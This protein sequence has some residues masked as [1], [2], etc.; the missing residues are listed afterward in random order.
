MLGDDFYR[1]LRERVA[2]YTGPNAEYLLLAPDLFMLVGRLMLDPRVD[3]RHKAYLGIAMAYVISPIDL[4]PESRFGVIGYLDD[5]VVVVA[6]LNMLL[7]E[8]DPAIVLE[9]WS[10]NA[11]LLAKVKEILAQADQL[12]GVGR[13]EK[14][15]ETLGIRK[16]A[17]GTS[18]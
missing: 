1:Q 12:I 9:H 13:L 4:I 8:I 7:N 11:D 10:G 18:A 14:I 6:V 3:G 16:P 17:T 2:G 15:L 5:V